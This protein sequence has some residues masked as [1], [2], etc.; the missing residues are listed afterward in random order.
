MVNTAPDKAAAGDPFRREML[1][2]G[3]D[4]FEASGGPTDFSFRGVNCGADRGKDKD[5]NTHRPV[6]VYDGF[7]LHKGGLLA[8][9]RC[10]RRHRP[11]HFWPPIIGRVACS[12]S[13]TNTPTCGA[14]LTRTW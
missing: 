2:V 11:R 12:I 4:A 14:N 1:A 3:I 9:I 8:A 6:R 7:K 10:C 5:G 13:S